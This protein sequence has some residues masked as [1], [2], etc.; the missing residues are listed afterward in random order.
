MLRAMSV[1]TFALTLAFGLL[2]GSAQNW[3]A[4]TGT[5]PEIKTTPTVTASALMTL[6]KLGSFEI[7][8]KERGGF[9]SERG[10]VPPE[11]AEYAR[12]ALQKDTR[13]NYA[14]PAQGI[15]KFQCED[16]DCHRIKAEVT[17]G[18]DGPVL[19]QDSRLYKLC[20]F[21]NFRFLPDSQK[22]A[23]KMV[24]QLAQDYEAAVKAGSIKIE[25]KEE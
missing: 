17:Y 9:S 5:L 22:F 14:S 20:P 1:K 10:E 12:T 11:L 23:R 16:S 4:E 6:G 8:A 7:S 19:W 25:I 24:E 21:I 15:L 3:A 13:L 18:E 2:S